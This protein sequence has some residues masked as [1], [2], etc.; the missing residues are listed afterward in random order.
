L[1][2]YNH[3]CESLPGADA[4]DLNATPDADGRIRVRIGPAVPATLNNRVDTLGRR[5]GA[6]IFRAIGAAT[7]QLPQVIVQR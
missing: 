2:A 6:L 5:R 7:R 3:W 4:H 1:H